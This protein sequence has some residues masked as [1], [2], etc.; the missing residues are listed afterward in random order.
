ATFA[1]AR[2]LCEAL[3]EPPEYLQVMFWLVTASVIRGELVHAHEAIDTLLRLADARGDRPAVLN[4]MR[5]QAMILLFMGRLVDAREAIE[6]A[7]GAF[8]GSTDAEQLAARAAGQDAGTANLS[9]MSWALWALGCVDEAVTRINAALHRADSVQHPHS[10]AYASYYA[11]VL[12]SLRGEQQIARQYA[13]RCLALSEDHGFGQWRG[14]SRAVRAICMSLLDDSSTTLPI[15]VSALDEYRRAGYQLGI[16]AL[17]VLVCPALLSSQSRDSV[18][19][20]IDQAL[21][22][23]SQNSER[24]FEAEL[25]RLKARALLVQNLP[26]SALQAEFWL[27]QAIS[28][29]RNQHARSLELRAAT[30]LASVWRSQNRRQEALVVLTPIYASFDEGHE[31]ADVQAAKAMLEQLR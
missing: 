6:R 14:L 11:A 2:E 19:E 10:Q 20:L 13:E 18:L 4:A 15:A 29:A 16:T 1:R 22:I 9:L 31:T 12:H 7:V 23:S 27:Q 30:D 21:S 3:G 24:L 5:G 17:Y 26:E 28:T 8:S 25:Y